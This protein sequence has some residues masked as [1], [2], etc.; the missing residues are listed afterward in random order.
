M[1]D[2]L[3]LPPE[4]RKVHFAP[5]QQYAILE[6]NTDLPIS[7]LTFVGSESGPILDIAGILNNADV[8]SFSP[9]GTRLVLYSSAERRLQLITGL[10]EAG[11]VVREISSED[12][13]EEDLKFVALNDNGLTLLVGTTNQSIYRV[14]KGRPPEFLN[15]VGNLVAMMFRPQSDAALT[16]DSDTGQLLLLENLESTPSRRLLLDGLNIDRHAMMQIDGAA[17]IITSK[18]ANVLLQVDLGTSEV[19]ELLLST[20]PVTLQELRASH[21]FLLSYDADQ[22]AWI[23]VKSDEARD[24]YFVPRANLPEKMTSMAESTF[25][26]AKECGVRKPSSAGQL[27]ILSGFRGVFRS[28]AYVLV[29]Q[30]ASTAY[31]SA[32]SAQA[33][34]TNSGFTR[35]TC[36]E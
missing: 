6:R 21:S 18:A 11:Q 26:A 20:S 36:P 17:A 31:V 29:V 2:R 4:V 24:V 25:M 12:L 5:K 15:S 19:Q 9:D 33:V 34:R 22:P 13:P 3:E 14:A 35:T 10:P 27:R 32:Q 28:I 23:L 1:S 30:F 16:L 7:I 8:L